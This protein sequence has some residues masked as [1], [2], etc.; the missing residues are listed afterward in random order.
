MLRSTALLLGL[1]ATFATIAESRWVTDELS[2][3]MRSGESNRHKILRPLVSGTQLEV[4][5]NNEETGFSLIKTDRG[6]EGYVLTRFLVNEPVARVKLAQAENQIAALTQS[7]EPARLQLSQQQETIDNLKLNLNTAQAK[8]ATLSA[9]LENIKSISEDAIKINEQ[10]KLALE[11]KQ[12]LE[13]ELNVANQENERLQDRSK[14]EWFING[15]LAVLL[16]VIIAVLVPRLRPP[17]RHSEW[18]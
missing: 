13:S 7:S 6:Q 12:I 9:E 11:R 15:A 16:G 18:I 3:M 8:N 17:R 5:S 14:R 10:L 2:I 4:I 1:L